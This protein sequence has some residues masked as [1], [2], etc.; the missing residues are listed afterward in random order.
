MWLFHQSCFQGFSQVKKLQSDFILSLNGCVPQI[1]NCS[2]LVI[3]LSNCIEGELFGPHY[4]SQIITRAEQRNG[5]MIAKLDYK[6]IQTFILAIKK[7]I[8]V[9]NVTFY[10]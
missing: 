1:G 5:P 7:K 2:P 4:R 10:I 6:K 9:L 8:V 3:D